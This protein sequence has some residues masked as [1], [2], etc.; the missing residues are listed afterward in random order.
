MKNEFKIPIITIDNM[1]VYSSYLSLENC[2]K[3]YKYS[4]IGSYYRE[5]DYNVFGISIEKYDR[6]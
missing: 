5:V 4:T 2:I 3:H 6:I 1:N